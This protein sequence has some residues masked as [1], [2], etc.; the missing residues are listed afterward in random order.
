MPRRDPS[1]GSAQIRGIDSPGDAGH[2]RVRIWRADAQ[3]PGLRRIEGSLTLGRDLLGK[4]ATSDP[5][6]VPLLAF[7]GSRIQVDVRKKRRFVWGL[8]GRRFDD[9]P[10][11]PGSLGR[12][13]TWVVHPEQDESLVLIQ[14][15]PPERV[16]YLEGIVRLYRLRVRPIR[17]DIDSPLRIEPPCVMVAGLGAVE[18]TSR[19]G[20]T[21]L[22]QPALLAKFNLDD[23]RRRLQAFRPL[24]TRVAVPCAVPGDR[25]WQTSEHEAVAALNGL[26]EGAFVGTD[27]PDW[28]LLPCSLADSAPGLILARRASAGWMFTSSDSALESWIHGGCEPHGTFLSAVS[29]PPTSRKIVL[30][31]SRSKLPALVVSAIHF[32]RLDSQ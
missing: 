7:T 6:E 20:S 1:H 28:L 19:G 27:P 12:Y 2:P 23:L 24:E 32:L 29:P 15:Q 18:V 9:F 21:R 17:G 31:A 3:E 16:S 11:H 13:W 26:L 30:I 10:G 14:K 25:H 5:N 8:P 4:Y 22:G